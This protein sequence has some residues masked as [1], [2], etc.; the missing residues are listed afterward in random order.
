MLTTTQ[1]RHHMNKAARYPHK[2]SKKK[3]EKVNIS[4]HQS[5]S[6]CSTLKTC[7]TFK[8]HHQ[9]DQYQG[10][11]SYSNVDDMEEPPD[12][13]RYPIL[14][15]SMIPIPRKYVAS[16]VST[17]ADTSSTHSLSS[18][19]QGVSSSIDEKVDL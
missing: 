12:I 5:A 14:G 16:S 18:S 2:P 15:S 7:N 4:R 19:S 17:S 1:A 11:K 9:H 3:E 6:S 13:T 8:H 10:S